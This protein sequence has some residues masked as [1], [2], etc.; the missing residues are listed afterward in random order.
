MEQRVVVW[1][2]ETIYKVKYFIFLSIKKHR[3]KLRA[4][5]KDRENTGN[6]VLIGATLILS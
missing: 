1:V 2:V 3:E 4:Q 6:L 5:E